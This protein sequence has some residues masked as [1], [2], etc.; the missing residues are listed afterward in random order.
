VLFW[1]ILGAIVTRGIFIFAGVTLI[2][3]FHWVI[4]LLG[5]LLVATGA[6]LGLSGGEQVHPERN[7]VVRWAS[8]V[9]PMVKSY[10][11]ERFLVR[12]EGAWRFTPLML[13][14]LAIESTDVMFAVDSVPAVLAVSRD[15]F[16]VYSSTSSRSWACAPSTSFSPARCGRSGCFALRLRS[17]WCWWASRCWSPTWSRSRPRPRSWL[18]P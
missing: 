17:S 7:L 14:L 11:G 18:W 3:H 10:H 1:G 15:A 6:R 12:V 2:S 9:L 5:I 13:V 16:V 8:R 4:Y